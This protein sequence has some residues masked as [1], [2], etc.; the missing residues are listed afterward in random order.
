[1]ED[2]LLVIRNRGAS[3]TRVV[4]SGK[5]CR[6]V[7]AD[8]GLPARAYCGTADA[9]LWRSDDG[10]NSW[11]PAGDGIRHPHVT[12][13][14]VSGT[15]RGERGQGV[16]YAGT[17]PSAAFRSEDGGDH[18]QALSGLLDLPSAGSWSF[19]PRPETHH[20]RWIA[21]DPLV[22]GRLFVA[23]EA[24]ALVRSEDGGRTWEDRAPGGP[25]DTHT[26]VVHPRIPDRLYSAAGDGYFESHDAGGTWQKPEMGLRHPYVWG[27]VV[28][29]EDPDT[30]V[31]SAA[32]SAGAAHAASHAESWIY[33]RTAGEPWEAVRQGLPEPAGTTVST[34]AA[35]PTERGVIYAANNRGAFRSS[36]MGVSWRSLDIVWPARFWEQRAAGLA[37]V[38]EA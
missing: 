7:A 34:L 14:A 30:V 5:R 35:D 33:R 23:I 27:C 1:M 29:A 28:D 8:P 11:S 18:W 26:L 38:R 2:A 6:S 21:P 4:L 22:P 9:G 17:E 10:G 37:V 12:A 13:V 3:E 31:V 24:G 32:R 20:V 19:P 15:E 16:V 25:R 36:D